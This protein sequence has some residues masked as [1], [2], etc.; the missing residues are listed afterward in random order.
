[1]LN[2]KKWLE[3]T[4]VVTTQD[5]YAVDALAHIRDKHRCCKRKTPPSTFNPEKKFGKKKPK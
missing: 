3:D 1:M 4:G 5:D 2:F